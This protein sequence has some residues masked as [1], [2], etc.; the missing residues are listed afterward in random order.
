MVAGVDEAGRGPLAGPVLAAAAILDPNTPIEGLDDSKKLSAARRSVLE[1][2][3]KKKALY[4]AVASASV[5]E[6]DE[7]NILQATLLAMQRAVDKLAII[8]TKALV[9]GNQLPRLPCTG[10][11]V[12]GGDALHAEISAASI[13]AKQAR[14]RQM[15]ALANLYPQYGFERHKGYPTPEHIAAL[16]RYGISIHHRRSYAPVKKYLSI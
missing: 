9:D 11:A 7:M 12:V 2:E 1:T 14:D 10:E 16:R 15:L 4:W 13:L 6:I 8:P 3:I 5:A